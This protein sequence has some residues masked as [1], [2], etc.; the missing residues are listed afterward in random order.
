MRKGS[1]LPVNR[2]LG[3]VKGN[4]ITGVLA[5]GGLLAF[6]IQGAGAALLFL[7]EVVAARLLGVNQ[8]GIYALVTAWLYILLM[9]GALSLN[10]VLLRFVPTYLAQEDWGGLRGLL[11]RSNQ[12]AGAAGIVLA[13]G[14]GALLAALRG[15]CVETVVVATFVPALIALPFQV[16]SSLRQATL[17]GMEKIAHA[18]L[19]EFVLRPLLFLLLLGAAAYFIDRPLDAKTAFLLNLAAVIAAFATGAIWQRRHL[20]ARVRAAAPAYRD[21]EWLLTALSLLLV[22]G[23]NLISSRLD[24]VMLGMLSGAR[25]V[26]VYSAASR[27]AD[28]ITFGLACANAVVAPMIARLHATG[29]QQELQHLVRQAARGVF[30]FTLPVA[31]L[32]VVF[33]REILGLFGMDFREGYKVLAVLVCGQLVNAL[34]GPVGYLMMM[35]GHQHA[36]A[37]IV[38]GTALLNLTLNAVLI[39]LLGM[40]GAAIATATSMVMLNLL[41]LRTVRLRLSLE[42]SAIQWPFR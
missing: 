39:P 37:R 10:H 5:R 13:C 21:R 36:A 11:R 7:V 15:C 12:W 27:V 23:L 42:P 35:T 2:V 16:L 28:V 31:L 1:F 19:P 33:G 18:L 26:G 34:A 17:R 6:L 24:V 38:A 41:M 4:G 3:L 8:F 20:P 25:E 40:I 22:V 29:R 30:L 9:V 32:I 14:G